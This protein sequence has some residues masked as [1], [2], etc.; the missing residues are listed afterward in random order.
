M[1][2]NT[3]EEIHIS[4]DIRFKWYALICIANHEKSVKKTI[5][6]EIRKRGLNNWVDIIHIPTMKE[7]IIQNGKSITRDKTMIPG[8]ILIH[9]DIS[10]SELIPTIKNSKGVLSWLNPS[11][12]KVKQR[13]EVVRER[14]IERL[15]KV[16]R[17]NNEILE[18]QFNVGET[19]KLIDGVFSGMIGVIEEIK[20]DKV[21]VL[22]SIFGRKTPTEMKKTEIE[23]IK[24]EIA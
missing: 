6:N 21:L 20:N 7:V 18:S 19:V 17:S 4:S 15:L 24:T 10:N 2:V 14:D 22:V 3:Q 8:Y 13:P 16:S 12:G 23:K 1:E 11:E 9:M 5:E